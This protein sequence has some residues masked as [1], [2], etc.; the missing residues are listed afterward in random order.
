MSFAEDLVNPASLNTASKMGINL[1]LGFL[2]LKVTAIINP[3]NVAPIRFP[4]RLNANP[5]EMNN[6]AIHPIK[7]PDLLKRTDMTV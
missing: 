1:I 5:R 6:R 2:K 4:P 3:D 7:N